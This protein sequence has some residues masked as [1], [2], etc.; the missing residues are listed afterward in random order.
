MNRTVKYSWDTAGSSLAKVIYIAPLR[1]V[2]CD[3]RKNF[4][5]QSLKCDIDFYL[6]DFISGTILNVEWTEIPSKGMYHGF[7]YI[8]S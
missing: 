1:W 5:L 7:W 8:S 3:L 6:N 4:T 2:R